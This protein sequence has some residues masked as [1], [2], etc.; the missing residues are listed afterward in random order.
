MILFYEPEVCLFIKHLLRRTAYTFGNSIQHSE[1]GITWIE[2]DLMW[3]DYLYL[4][5]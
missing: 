3:D 1:I 5:L 2:S 4:N